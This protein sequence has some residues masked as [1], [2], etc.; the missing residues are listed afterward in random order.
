MLLT[1]AAILESHDLQL[2]TIE[3]P[4]WGG[5]VNVRVMSGLERDR[6][7]GRLLDIDKT[8]SYDNL[9]ATLVAV[10]VCDSS[11]KRLFDDADI[12]ALGNKS[13]AALSRVYEAA[14]RV[15]A[16]TLASREELA[17]NSDPSPGDNS[18]SD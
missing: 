12:A 3:V 13:A 8:K 11:G 2:E 6:W 14:L 9:R 16:L 10:T 5:V 1:K 15:N 17:K 18:P 7:D 4:E